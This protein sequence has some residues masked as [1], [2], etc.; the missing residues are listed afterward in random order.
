[1]YVAAHC[2]AGRA[3]RGGPA[4]QRTSPSVPYALF[5]RARE[6]EERPKHFSREERRW[7]FTVAI[8]LAP[9]VVCAQ[10]PMLKNSKQHNFDLTTHEATHQTMEMSIRVKMFVEDAST[11]VVGGSRGTAL[12][13]EEYV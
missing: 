7:G 4:S 11:C 3:F 1:M 5:R 10:P 6:A 9:C 2:S 8:A 12:F 13:K